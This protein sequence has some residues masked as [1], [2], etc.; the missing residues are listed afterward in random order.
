MTNAHASA[1]FLPK[2]IERIMNAPLIGPWL[3][4]LISPRGLLGKH[5]LCSIDGQSA[6]GDGWTRPTLLPTAYCRSFD[7][8]LSQILSRLLGPVPPRCA[9]AG[10]AAGRQGPVRG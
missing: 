7:A 2:W 6:V 4:Q 1:A 5:F 3:P 9:G 10:L 8:N